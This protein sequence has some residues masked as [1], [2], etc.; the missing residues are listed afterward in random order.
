MEAAFAN[1]TPLSI[2][3]P[4]PL[5]KRKGRSFEENIKEVTSTEAEK[6]S[7]RKDTHP[8]LAAVKVNS[9]SLSKRK[10]S[11]SAT[12]TMTLIKSSP[13]SPRKRHV[14]V[15]KASHQD[16]EQNS[17]YKNSSVRPI[18]FTAEQTSQVVLPT[19]GLSKG[20]VF[21]ANGFSSN[22]LVSFSPDSSTQGMS[23]N[24]ATKCL[25]T[26]TQEGPLKPS[27]SVLGIVDTKVTAELSKIPCGE[28]R[29]SGQASDAD[30]ERDES[31]VDTL[32]GHHENAD[33]DRLNRDSV[34][35]SPEK[36]D[37]GLH[38][39]LRAMRLIQ[40]EKR[41]SK[42]GINDDYYSESS[43]TSPIKMAENTMEHPPSKL[44]L[45]P[46]TAEDADEEDNATKE[47]RS[48]VEKAGQLLLHPRVKRA[49]L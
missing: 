36:D 48:P 13:T 47:N 9:H 29:G 30:D 28:Y 27:S 7:K 12:S 49:K 45:S 1:V 42:E 8:Q 40:S 38:C 22:V 31:D 14:E 37:Q 18:G 32:I 11:S 35:P 17:G 39:K 6:N 41:R 43:A 21:S 24:F 3:Y 33:I 5:S 34:V 46:G 15:F 20:T 2:A 25:T 26:D 16:D 4:L 44:G 23:S 19:S 10:Q